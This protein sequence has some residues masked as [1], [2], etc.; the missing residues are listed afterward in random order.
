M[1]ARRATALALVLLVGGCAF[2][3]RPERRFYSLEVIAPRS[4]VAALSGLPIGI[5]GLELPPQNVRREIV[6]RQADGQ[7]DVRGTEL[8]AGPIEAM[9][10]HTLAFNLAGRMP[11]GMVVLPGQVRPQ[12]AMRSLNLVFEELSAGPDN[13]V[14]A[15][16]RWTVEGTT[17]RER[18]T[19]PLTSLGS[20]QIASGISQL[21]ATLADR[22]VAGLSA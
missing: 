1:T 2:F 12:G 22:I 21:L 20:A 7:L 11:E 10:I 8:W 13:V 6:A 19:L 9:M 5:D 17:R 15:D 18:L 4:A 3:R 14:V 16:V